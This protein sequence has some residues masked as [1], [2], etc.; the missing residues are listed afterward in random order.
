MLT[1]LSQGVRSLILAP[2][3]KPNKFSTIETAGTT[4]ILH[5]INQAGESARRT[6]ELSE[7]PTPSKFAMH[8]SKR[9]A[10]QPV[11]RCV[12]E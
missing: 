4:A 7:W 6:Q 5:Q 10:E 11:H 1:T 12:G 3:H 2:S 9:A 8:A